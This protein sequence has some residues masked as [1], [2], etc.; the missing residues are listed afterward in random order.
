M[1]CGILCCY[2]S[3]PFFGGRKL[4][5]LVFLRG[6]MKK[7]H[8]G[9]FTWNLQIT[10]LERKMIWTKPPGNY[11]QMF[12]LQ[13]CKSLGFEIF[14]PKPTNLLH[15]RSHPSSP[16]LRCMSARWVWNSFGVKSKSSTGP[17]GFDV[18]K[19]PGEV[20]RGVRNTVVDGM[21]W[22]HARKKDPCYFGNRLLFFRWS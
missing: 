8:P 21:A 4:L 5:N 9:R 17:L 18:W 16:R 1:T 2:Y 3:P 12:N 14:T 10:H 20:F 19:T 7:L 6:A 11:V 22:F 15:R 13:G